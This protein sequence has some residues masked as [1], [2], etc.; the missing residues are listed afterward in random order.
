M[1]NAAIKIQV[2]GFVWPYGL[3]FLEYFPVFLWCCFLH[4]PSELD[5][6]IR[7]T[8]QNKVLILHL[9]IAQNIY[10]IKVILID[11]LYIS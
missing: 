4:N 5:L 9:K 11:H 10:I 7:W 2:Q 8:Y 6:G 1:N 3:H